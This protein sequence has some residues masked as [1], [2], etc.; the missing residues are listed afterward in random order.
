MARKLGNGP[1]TGGVL[2]S[3]PSTEEIEQKVIA[4]VSEHLARE[5]S[6]ITRETSYVNDLN[7]DSLDIVEVVMDLEEAYDMNVPD[8]DAQKIDTIGA[9]VDYIHEQLTKKAEGASASGD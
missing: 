2:V 5:P 4:I 3:I 9:T 6:E 1:V 7:A 8:E